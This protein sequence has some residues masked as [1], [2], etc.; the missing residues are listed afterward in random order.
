MKQAETVCA[1]AEW[2]YE[3]IR[4]QTYTGRFIPDYGSQDRR[5]GRYRSGM[6]TKQGDIE[7]REWVAYAEELVRR[8][9]DVELFKQLKSWYRDT[10]HWLDGEKDLKKYTLVCLIDG[11]P[12]DPQWVDYIAF[13]TKYRPER[14]QQETTG[15]RHNGNEK[16]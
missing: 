13:N 1:P 14:L 16:I 5:A 10:V 3:D 15:E 2:T 9:G 8:N 11:I 12:D 7:E 4:V 6:L